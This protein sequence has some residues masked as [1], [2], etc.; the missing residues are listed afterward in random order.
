MPCF[1]A[2]PQGD[3]AQHLPQF[4]HGFIGH[5]LRLLNSF[6]RFL[7]PRLALRTP[8]IAPHVLLPAVV[9]ARTAELDAQAPV[10]A[11][12]GELVADAA[13]RQLVGELL[14]LGH[15]KPPKSFKSIKS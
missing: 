14:E 9:I 10:D 11:A 12:V 4:S 2:I 1:S 13:S 3:P 15:V 8:M 5:A 6:C 7:A